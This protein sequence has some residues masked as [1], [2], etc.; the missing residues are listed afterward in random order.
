[1]KAVTDLW[2][3]YQEK[4]DKAREISFYKTHKLI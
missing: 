3:E 4:F 1:M 2:Y